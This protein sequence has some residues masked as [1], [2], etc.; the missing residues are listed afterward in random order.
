MAL[1]EAVDLTIELVGM[2]EVRTR[3]PHRDRASRL[4][5]MFARAGVAPPARY[6]VCDALQAFALQRNTDAVS[7]MPQPLLGNP[8]TRD[9]V[10][11]EDATI[12]P[13]DLEL[14]MMTRPDTP[15]TPAAAY[16]AHC[17]VETCRRVA[18]EQAA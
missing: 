12:Q 8:E 7:I 10:L 6:V 14:A 18:G 1:Q 16:F 3:Q 11:I 17:I 4:A 2:L 9:I 13:F 15:L 5:E